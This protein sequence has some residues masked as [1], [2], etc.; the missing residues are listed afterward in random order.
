MQSH[1]S[2]KGLAADV[3][4][5]VENMYPLDVQIPPLGFAI[6]V[7]NCLPSDPHIPLADALT[8]ATHVQPKRD[9]WINVTSFVQQL[10]EAFLNTCPGTIDSPFDTLLGKYIHGHEATLYVS[11]SESPSSSTPQWISDLAYGVTVPVSFPGRSLGNLM[12]NFTMTDVHFSL[13]DF[14]ADPNTPESQ[15][16][17]S[18][19]IKALIDLPDEMNFQVDVHRIRST[20]DVFYHKKKLGVLDIS[21]WHQ[22]NSKEI[23]EPNVSHPDLEITS[24][25]EKAP[26]SITNQR[27]F[28]EV[29]RALLSG[30]SNVN[31]SVKA[32]VDVQMETPL[33]ELAVREI[34]AKGEVPVKRTTTI[35]FLEDWTKLITS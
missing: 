29:V 13:P 17:I 22:A 33:G 25:I 8:R 21:K 5:R 10:P 35:S 4:I 7:D 12:K 20:A 6:G 9:V 18:A 3:S 28:N 15:P 2:Y 32:L 27:V 24:H 11:G 30:S 23:K 31:L 34:P 16:K 19:Q 1:N 14:F 26:L